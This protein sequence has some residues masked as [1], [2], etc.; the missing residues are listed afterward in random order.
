MALTNDLVTI[1]GN[2]GNDPTYNTTRSGDPVVNFRVGSSSGYFDKNSGSWVD[3]GT[4]WYAV[5]AFRDL[6]EHGKASLRRG[7]PVIVTGSLKIK[8]WEN[9][10]RKG[11]SADIVASAIGH[12]LNKGTSAFVRRPKPGANAERTRTE[13]PESQSGPHDE[14]QTYDPVPPQ[15]EE[16]WAASGMTITDTADG[17]TASEGT[18]Q[19]QEE[20]FA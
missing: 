2:I 9:E 8:E 5:S 19:E 10:G 20:A 15:L 6:A 18:T 3:E 12:D 17:A 4:S 14:P 13:A 16:A 7:D 1:S 11:T